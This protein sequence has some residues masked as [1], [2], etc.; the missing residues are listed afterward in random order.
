MPPR[1]ATMAAATIDMTVWSKIAN[2]LMHAVVCVTRI[3]FAY[4]SGRHNQHLRRRE[5]YAEGQ[6]TSLYLMHDSLSRTHPQANMLIYDEREVV[7]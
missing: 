1:L 3:S 2:T 4:E 7:P 6:I 5:R